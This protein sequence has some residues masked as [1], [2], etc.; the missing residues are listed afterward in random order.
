MLRLSK[1]RC[2]YD[3]FSTCLRSLILGR[4]R[5]ETRYL[6]KKLIINTRRY[7]DQK[8]VLYLTIRM[9]V[10]APESIANPLSAL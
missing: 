9:P 3:I 1:S 8:D 7:A 5:K 6:R 2:G 10:N 4:K